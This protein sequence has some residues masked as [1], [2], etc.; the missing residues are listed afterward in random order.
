MAVQANNLIAD[1]GDLPGA[2]DL[3]TPDFWPDPR[4]RDKMFLEDAP[5]MTYAEDAP[6]PLVRRFVPGRLRL[7]GA[8]QSHP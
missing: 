6:R 5:D 3:A 2:G 1:A 4:L 7:I 8:L